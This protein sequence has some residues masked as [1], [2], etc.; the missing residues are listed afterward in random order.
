M[1]RIPL[2]VCVIALTQNDYHDLE[3]DRFRNLLDAA[4]D[5]FNF[6]QQG[7]PYAPSPDDWKP[8]GE[9]WPLVDALRAANFEPNFLS[10]QLYNTD[11][12]GSVRE[13]TDLYIIDPLVLMHRSKRDLL[14]R[15]VQATILAA[16]RAFCIILPA[17]LPPN[18]RDEIEN[19]CTNSLRDLHRVWVDRDGCE[20]EIEKTFRLQAFFKRLAHQFSQRPNPANLQTALT[21]FA[22]RGTPPVNLTE[23]P[24]LVGG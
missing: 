6:A 19:A 1:A 24:R 16:R 10:N 20:W 3:P 15:E 22:E 14:I 18:L 11:A 12:G 9:N 8:F 17:T 7:K 5:C 4:A 13:I 21:I 2:S 23:L